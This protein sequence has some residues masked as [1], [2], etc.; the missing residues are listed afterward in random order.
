MAEAVWGAAQPRVATIFLE[1]PAEGTT[2]LPARSSANA[3]LK[4]LMPLQ[5]DTWP[6]AD[7]G[8]PSMQV[9]CCSASA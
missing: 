6:K 4:K 3:A 1:M 5:N 7:R 9:P 2:S 8:S